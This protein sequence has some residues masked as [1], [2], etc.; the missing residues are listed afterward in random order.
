MS[1]HRLLPAP[2]AATWD[3]AAPRER[4]LVS[5][6]AAIVAIGIGWGLLWQPLRAD[7]DRTRSELSRA[8]AVLAMSRTLADESA[9]L[10]RETPAVHA[11]DLRTAV[12]RVLGERGL[13]AAGALDVK[14]N[15]ITV[16]LPDARFDAL[17]GALEALRTSEGLRAVEA[18]LTPR[19][20]PGT[21]RAEIVLAR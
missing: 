9:G 21:V 10:A 1:S 6:G 5:A 15:R 17:I 12:A 4:R 7:I 3:R 13:R 20:E 14:D 19:V 16:V 2:F 8:T 11:A 18:T